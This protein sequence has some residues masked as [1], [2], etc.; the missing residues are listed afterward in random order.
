MLKPIAATLALTLAATAAAAGPLPLDRGL[1]VVGAEQA[2]QIQ[3]RP[4][5][6]P[7]EPRSACRDR[8]RWERDRNHGRWVWRNGRYENAHPG[9]AVAAGILGFA[10]GAAISGS[11]DDYVYYQRHRNDRGWRARCRDLPGFDWRSG[12]FVGRDGYRHYCTR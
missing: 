10:L 2:T 11:N 1:A 9:A 3:W 8:Q 4:G 7:G 5:C 12:T 6:S